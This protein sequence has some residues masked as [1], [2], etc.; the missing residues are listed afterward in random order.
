MFRLRNK[1]KKSITCSCVHPVK[2]CI[3][4]QI[5]YHMVSYNEPEM[6]P[7]NIKESQFIISNNDVFLSLKIVLS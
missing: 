2:C 3:L 5:F 1:K 6:V 4:K 7:C